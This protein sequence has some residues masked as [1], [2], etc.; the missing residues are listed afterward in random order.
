MVDQG[1]QFVISLVLSQSSSL[2]PSKLLAMMTGRATSHILTWSKA[3][4]NEEKNY[5]NS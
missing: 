3:P 5:E 4:K 2:Q 1:Q